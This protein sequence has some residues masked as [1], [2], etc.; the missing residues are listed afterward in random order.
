MNILP[1][2][3][4][5][6]PLHDLLH[7]SAPKAQHSL[8][9][10]VVSQKDVVQDAFQTVLDNCDANIS[11]GCLAPLQNPFVLPEFIGFFFL[12]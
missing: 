6:S 10:V 9:L 4:F 11:F 5:I 12:E 3:I 2:L 7:S 8:S 1:I